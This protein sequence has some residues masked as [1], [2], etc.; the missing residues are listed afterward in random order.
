[1]ASIPKIALD[2][3]NDIG[4]EAISI[5]INKTTGDNHPEY[6]RAVVAGTAE[7][8]KELAKSDTTTAIRVYES[9]KIKR[10]QRDFFNFSKILHKFATLVK[11][12]PKEEIRD[13]N[14]FFWNAIEHAKC[15]SSEGMQEL[16]AKILAGEYITPGSYSMHTLQTLKML[17]KN[18]LELFEKICSLLINGDEIPQDIFSMPESAKALMHELNID[19]GSLQLLQS[20]GLFLP[21]DMSRPMENLEK[22][23]FKAIYF[24]KWILFAP[25]TPENTDT[26]KINMPGFFGLSPVGKQLLKHLNP[27]SN[28]SY[29]NWLKENYKI[30]NYKI[31]E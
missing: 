8:I 3:I 16:I 24:D 11:I 18:E 9:I 21:N 29:F 12:K 5:V 25:I 30:P 2:V 28:D 31:L 27:K 7:A 22:K 6:E 19:F 17:G 1:M 13:D 10:E 15:V 23:N 26:L 4:K 20:L 14:D